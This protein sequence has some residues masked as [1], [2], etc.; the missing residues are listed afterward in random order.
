M[1]TT[2]SKRFGRKHAPDCR[3]DYNFT[4]GSCLEA[5]VLRAAPVHALPS[6]QE[7]IVVNVQDDE[8]ALDEVFEGVKGN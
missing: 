4:C 3:C 5:N 7:A 1:T 8:G 6:L 2:G